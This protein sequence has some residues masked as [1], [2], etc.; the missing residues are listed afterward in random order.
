MADWKCS[1]CG[2]VKSTRCKPR[3]CPECGQSGTF[4]KV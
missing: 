2:F 1:N 3:K 4:E